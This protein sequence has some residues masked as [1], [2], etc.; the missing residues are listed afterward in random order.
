MGQDTAVHFKTSSGSVNSVSLP[1]RPTSGSLTLVTQ[2]TIDKAP[3]LLY[4]SNSGGK[5]EIYLA[6]TVLQTLMAA[7]CN[8]EK[9]R[10]QM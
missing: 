1:G 9:N 7:L 3:L 8:G 2:K 5:K 10:L 4:R 6:L